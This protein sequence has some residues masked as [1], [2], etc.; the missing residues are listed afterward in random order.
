MSHMHLFRERHQ[1]LNH[2]CSSNKTLSLALG[3]Q[4]H[5][6]VSSSADKSQNVAKESRNKKSN[7]NN[8]QRRRLTNR[9]I[10]SRRRN[11]TLSYL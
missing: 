11:Q 1:Y 6:L 2:K 3:D 7:F 9:Q 8:Y 5:P 10:S 4:E